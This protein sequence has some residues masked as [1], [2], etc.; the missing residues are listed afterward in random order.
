MTDIEKTAIRNMIE[1]LKNGEITSEE[2]AEWIK[3]MGISP[4]Q[5]SIYISEIKSE[6][7]AEEW[8]REEQAIKIQ[9]TENQESR[10]EAME[11]NLEVIRYGSQGKQFKDLSAE[12]EKFKKNY[13]ELKE[14]ANWSKKAL[15]HATEQYHKELIIREELDKRGKDLI[16]RAEELRTSEPHDYCEKNKELFKFF[17]RNSGNKEIKTES[18]EVQETYVFNTIFD[19]TLK[20]QETL[21]NAIKESKQNLRAWKRNMKSHL[22]DFKKFTK[23]LKEF[24]KVEGSEN[25]SAS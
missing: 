7:Q 24:E 14:K 23:L 21:I 15:D 19:A 8:K 1:K 6:E 22:E 17:L 2:I 9:E 20:D 16:E 3:V 11:E 10:I 25:G 4:Q 13:M 5:F 12:Y 18:I